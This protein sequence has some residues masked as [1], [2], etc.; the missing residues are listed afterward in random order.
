MY[1]KMVRKY[2]WPKLSGDVSTKVRSF[3]SCEKTRRTLMSYQKNLLL[4]PP[5]GTLEFFA[6]GLLGTLPTTRRGHISVLVN[7]DRY[8]NIAWMV[9]M[10]RIKEPQ[11]TEDFLERCIVPYG[12]PNFVQIDNGP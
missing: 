12:L 11:C 3:T 7:T 10:D 2:F 8:C 6:M 9:A 1:V 5:V 4:F